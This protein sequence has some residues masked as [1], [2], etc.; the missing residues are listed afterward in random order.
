MVAGPWRGWR[1]V[2]GLDWQVLETGWVWRESDEKMPLGTK[3]R[4]CSKIGG[5]GLDSVGFSLPFVWPVL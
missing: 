2:K 4:P 1:E 3:S 5:T